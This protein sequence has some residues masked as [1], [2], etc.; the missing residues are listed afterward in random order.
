MPQPHRQ[1]AYPHLSLADPEH[2]GFIRLIRIV[3][4][5]P[6]RRTM[7]NMDLGVSFGIAGCG[8]DMMASKIVAKI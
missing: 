5:I 3:V 7:H 8:V 1:K 2:N 6:G 4:W